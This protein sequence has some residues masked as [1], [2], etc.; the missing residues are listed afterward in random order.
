MLSYRV[1]FRRKFF[2]GGR[3]LVKC[4]VEGDKPGSGAQEKQRY[5]Y[6]S[7]ISDSPL[8]FTMYLHCIFRV[9]ALHPAEPLFFHLTVI[10]LSPLFIPSTTPFILHFIPCCIILLHL[11]PSLYYT[12]VISQSLGFTPL[13]VTQQLGNLQISASIS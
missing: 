8:P 7:R 3:L 4:M 5:G 6:G 12:C 1:D 2:E 13:S 10:S 9:L 11:S